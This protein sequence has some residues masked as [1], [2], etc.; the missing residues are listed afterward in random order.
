LLLVFLLALCAVP[1]QAQRFI[2]EELAAPPGG[3]SRA[4]A[5]NSR[6]DV[7]GS[8]Y[9]VNGHTRAALWLVGK[10][11]RWLGPDT[12]FDTQAVDVND[13]LQ[14]PIWSSEPG[15]P[16]LLWDYGKTSALSAAPVAINN[17][18]TLLYAPPPGGI[19]WVALNDAG[20][21]LGGTW[22]GPLF[23]PAAGNTLTAIVD[24]DSVIHRPESFS[25]IAVNNR[26]QVL[27]NRSNDVLYMPGGSF[28]WREGVLTPVGDWTTMAA[29]LNDDR[30]VVG[31][32]FDSEASLYG[33][34]FP[35]LWTPRG[36]LVDLTKRLVNGAGW[37][38]LSA[39]AINNAGQIA[40]NGLKDGRPRAFRLTP[41]P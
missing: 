11:L 27:L 30:A 13:R 21:R 10:G 34:R 5:I 41:A 29:A 7:A 37:E 15:T 31:D 1:V 39:V 38:I 12:E 8:V 40:G 35:F 18:G 26:G 24:T 33:P 28:L 6:G 4:V 25:P 17:A 16:G 9:P 32:T 36:G 14:V 3:S 19:Q 20:D 22:D 23:R 2:V